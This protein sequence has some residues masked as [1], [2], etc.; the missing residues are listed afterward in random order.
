MTRESTHDNQINEKMNDESLQEQEKLPELKLRE[1]EWPE[2]K[3]QQQE[4][5]NRM[6]ISTISQQ[7]SMNKTSTQGMM[8]D[9]QRVGTIMTGNSPNNQIGWAKEG[10]EDPAK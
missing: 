5:H 8:P 1:A 6:K 4:E 9:K 3:Q 7:D 2:D 10:I